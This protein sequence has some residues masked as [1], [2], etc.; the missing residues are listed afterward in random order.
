WRAGAEVLATFHSS[1]ESLSH[2]Q[3]CTKCSGHVMINH[4]AFGVYD[5]FAGLVP[6]LKVVPTMHLNY[7]QAVLSMS[8]GSRKYKDFPSELNEFG[9]SGELM[10]E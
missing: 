6:T 1:P 10:V 9:G 4:P 8:G 2:C 7:S 5:V 3:Y